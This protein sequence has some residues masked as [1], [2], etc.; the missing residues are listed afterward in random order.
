MS[1]VGEESQRR[2]DEGRRHLD[3]KEERDEGERAEY[4]AT[5]TL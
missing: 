1:R 2:S 4:V 5:V 3:D